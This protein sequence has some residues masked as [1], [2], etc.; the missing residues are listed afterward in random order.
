MSD[1]E[2]QYTDEEVEEEEEETIEEPT[3]ESADQTDVPVAAVVQ[4]EPQEETKLRRIPPPQPKEVDGDS[5]TEAEAAMLA[6]KRRHEEE[7]AVKMLDYEERRRIEKEQAEEELRV[8]K[9]RQNARKAEREQEE[10]EFAARRKEDEERRRQEEEERK[11]HSEHEKLRREEEKRKRQQVMAGAFVGQTGAET[12]GGRNFTVGKGQG[13]QKLSNLGGEGSSKKQKSAEE[14]AEAKRNY[15][16]IVS[17]QVDISHL[18][19]NDLKNKIKQLHNKIVKLEAEKYDLEKRKDRQEYDLKELNE[20][21]KQAARN[22]ALAKGLDPVEASN[23]AHPPKITVASKFDRQTDRRSYV[24]RRIQFENPV[25][26]PAPAIAHGSCRPPSE[27][28]RKDLE[29]LESLRKTWSPKVCGAVIPLQLPS[30]GGEASKD[31]VA[32]PP[33][34]TKKKAR[35]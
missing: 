6:A 25:I 27:W 17:R 1:E 26:K 9:E 10:R 23:T 14:V 29:E 24:D 34:P 30:E 5:M 2:E 20:R 33:A 22:K 8:L 35:A 28:G 16:S 12:P 7:E 13:G 19:P 3:S 18:L 4:A 32:V 31:E 15:M 21:Q 11:A